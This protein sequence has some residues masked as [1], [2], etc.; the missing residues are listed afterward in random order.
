M[1]RCISNEFNDGTNITFRGSSGCVNTYF[2]T[3]TYSMMEPVLHCVL[4]VSIMDKKNIFIHIT[5]S[6]M[7][8]SQTWQYCCLC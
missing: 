1:C 4:S 8:V 5:C 2:E 6:L 7:Q 3:L